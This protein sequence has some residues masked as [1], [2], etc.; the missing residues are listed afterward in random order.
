[1]Q[2]QMALLEPTPDGFH[3]RLG[4]RLTPTVDGTVVREAL[5]R[6]PRERTSHPDVEGVMQE[7]VGQERLTTPPCGVPLTRGSRPPPIAPCVR[8]SDNL[9]LAMTAWAQQARLAS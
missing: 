1:M 5:K 9:E 3:D 8:P 7:E 6:T 4:L 2:L